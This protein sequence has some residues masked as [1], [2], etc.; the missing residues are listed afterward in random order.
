MLLLLLL[1]LL[2]GLEVGV[3]LL[4][5]PLQPLRLPLLLQLLP[6]VLLQGRRGEAGRME[7]GTR[8][9]PPSRQRPPSRPHLPYQQQGLFLQE[10]LLQDLQLPL[11]FL[12]LV[13]DVLL[14]GAEQPV[15]KG[16]QNPL[17]RAAASGLPARLKQGSRKAPPV[18][19]PPLLAPHLLPLGLPALLFPAHHLQV[20]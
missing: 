14:G 13:P 20:L 15:R 9:P 16:Q 19:P 4:E 18:V 1:L 6:L 17:P 7:G 11:L 2:Q 10:L 8:Q 5:L 3:L 12:Q